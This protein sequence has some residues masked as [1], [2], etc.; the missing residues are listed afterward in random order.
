MTELH[1]VGEPIE[2]TVE[3]VVGNHGAAGAT[4]GV[5]RHKRHARREL[6]VTQRFVAGPV[7]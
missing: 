6:D 5:A 4:I 2:I 7:L 1:V 3:L